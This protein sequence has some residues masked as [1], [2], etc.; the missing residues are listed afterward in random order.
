MSALALSHELSFEWR[1]VHNRIFMFTLTLSTFENVYAK[2]NIHNGFDV[3]VWPSW[4]TRA[5]QYWISCFDLTQ[6]GQIC[7]HKAW[8]CFHGNIRVHRDTGWKW[9]PPLSTLLLQSVEAFCATSVVCAVVAKGN[10]VKHKF[11]K[12][13]ALAIIF[14]VVCT[15][16]KEK[17]VS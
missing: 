6:Q 16:R 13:R 7:Q 14:S 17:E 9:L 10:H 2:G 1:T 12:Q 8:R 15:R 5:R 11:C 4:N 3:R